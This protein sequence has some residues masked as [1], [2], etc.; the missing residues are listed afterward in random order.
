M[1]N[2]INCDEVIKQK[3]DFFEQRLGYEQ[4]AEIDK[5]LDACESCRNEYSEYEKKLVINKS[6][7]T[8]YDFSKYEYALT[9]RIIGKVLKYGAITLFIWYILTYSIFPTLF[10]NQIRTKAEKSQIALK[11]LVAFTM[12]GYTRSDSNTN[13]GPWNHKIRI[14]LKSTLE[15]EDNFAGYIDAAVP[16]YMGEADIQLVDVHR[17]DKSYLLPSQQYY[18]EETKGG[19]SKELSEK[20]SSLPDATRTRFSIFFNRPVSAAEVDTLV[21]TLGVSNADSNNSWVAVDVSSNTQNNK[22]VHYR[23]PI[24][25][26]IWGFPLTFFTSVPVPE[27]ENDKLTNIGIGIDDDKRCQQSAKNFKAEMK[28]FQQYSVCLDDMALTKEVKRINEYLKNNEIAFY[29]A[30]L[31]APTKNI[32]KIK[33]VDFVGNIQIINVDFDY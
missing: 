18:S 8:S 31:A 3:E 19:I 25:G 9:M 16:M 23:N 11:D 24:S 6:S 4:M 32:L 15:Q 2:N 10:S 30:I 22:F 28:L 20:L 1:K 21:N 13:S 12:P 33:N 26:E 27:K 7:N 14:D 17:S 29:G 5:H